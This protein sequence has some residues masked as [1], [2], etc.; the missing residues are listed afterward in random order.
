MQIEQW[1]H[2]S[3]DAFLGEIHDYDQS[4]F[5]SISSVDMNNTSCI[6]FKIEI[7]K[8]IINITTGKQVFFAKSTSIYKIQNNNKVPTKRFLFGLIDDA[9]FDFAKEFHARTRN[10]NLD[11]H[12]IKRPQLEEQLPYLEQIEAKYVQGVKKDKAN[13]KPNWQETFRDL[14]PIPPYKKW[15]DGSHTT[16]EQDIS[17]KLLRNEEISKEEEE[18]FIT[19]SCFYQQLD[20]KLKD[21]D[22][23]TFTPDDAENFKN[24][25]LYAFN[26]VGL[27]KN[28]LTVFTTYC[29]V[30]NQDVTGKNEVITDTKFLK[31]PPLDV[32]KARGRYN[33]ANTPNTTLFYSAENINTAI[34]EI[35]PP[36]NRLVTV[37]VWAP[38]VPSFKLNVNVIS[39]GLPDAFVNEGVN[40]ANKAFV[41]LLPY[42]HPLFMQFME[43]YY[44]VLGNEFTKRTKNHQEFMT[45]ALFA[46]RLLVN[47]NVANDELLVD[48]IV[49][50][51]VGNDYN[52]ENIAMLPQTLENNFKLIKVIEFEIEEQY[53]D[54]PFQQSD[55]EDIQVAKIKNLRFA[56]G[57]SG[58]RIIW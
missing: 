27:I 4:Y 8:Q 32:V 46:E 42:N 47:E 57:S 28:T 36:L 56:K 40:K 49:Y 53:Y 18:I 11:S 23:T 39:H 24:Y 10:T 45:S 50:P 22:Y 3:I 6:I 12:K 7:E 20:V 5:L 14:P 9:T 19:L 29:I 43:Y 38:I 52:S 15:V 58:G 17:V 31:Y 21:L 25:I 1:H 30:V 41:E 51:S 34:R 26:Y 2:S 35:R 13:H 55:P 37:G 54:V 33:R 44:R 16:V 48:G